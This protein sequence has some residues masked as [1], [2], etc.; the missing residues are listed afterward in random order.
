MRS[1][2]RVCTMSFIRLTDEN[3]HLNQYIH[4]PIHWNACSDYWCSSNIWT[5]K[6]AAAAHKLMWKSS[7]TEH[8]EEWEWKR[9][10]FLEAAVTSSITFG[11]LLSIFSFSSSLRAVCWCAC[12]CLCVCMWWMRA[13]V[14][15]ILRSIFKRNKNENKSN[16]FP[17]SSMY[18]MYVRV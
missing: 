14:R 4:R 2:S 16:L 15:L 5:K 12:V 9:C 11:I 6:A 18:A 10:N 13:K 3:N 17:H 1:C 7:T 8:I